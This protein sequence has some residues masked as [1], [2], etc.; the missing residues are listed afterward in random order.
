ML[1]STVSWQGYLNYSSLFF[2]PFAF[3]F[4]LH[5]SE[6]RISA[7]YQPYKPMPPALHDQCAKEGIPFDECYEDPL[8]DQG[9]SN[10]TAASWPV[11]RRLN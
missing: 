5:V 11:L 10:V 9:S 4:Y 1:Q 8:I 3:T 2:P 6:P 7:S